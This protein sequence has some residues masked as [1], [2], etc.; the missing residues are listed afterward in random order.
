MCPA[1]IPN[2]WLAVGPL[3]LPTPAK[4]ERGMPQT[5]F[6]QV[7]NTLLYGLI[8]GCRWCDL[9]RGPQRA[10]KS[11]AHRWLRPWQDDGSL[12][13]AYDSWTR[14]PRIW[15]DMADRGH[16][17]RAWMELRPPEWFGPVCRRS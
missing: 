12:A 9:S 3:F 13:A 17:L 5:A 6:R 10:S 14:L 7:V 1:L 4:Q 8:T 16:Q 11:A 15:V 2:K